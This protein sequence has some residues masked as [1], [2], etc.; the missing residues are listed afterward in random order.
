MLLNADGTIRGDAYVLCAAEGYYILS[1]NLT[2][3]EVI[4]VLNEILVKA[5]DLDIQEIPEIKSMGED[6]W[7]V[8]MLEGPYAREVMAEVYG[9]D[10]IGL[11]YYEYMNTN[12]GLMVFVVG[13]MANS[14]IN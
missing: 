7:G 4:N 5:D 11:P 2:A 13:N 14:H 8:I 3:Q 9:F 12:D 6:D 1:E 10:I